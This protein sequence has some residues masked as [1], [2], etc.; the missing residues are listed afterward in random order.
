VRTIDVPANGLDRKREASEAERANV[1]K[2]LGLLA[3]RQLSATFYVVA[4]K[5]GG[6]RLSGAVDSD[7]DQACVVSLEP[8]RA[9]NASRF[10]VEFQADI[11]T[12]DNDEDVSIL[13]GPD[14]EL[15]EHGTIPVG[16]IVFET[17]SASL[18]PYPRAEGAEFS[19]A[20]PLQSKG[21]GDSPFAALSRLK[22]KD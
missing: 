4:I 2:A 6:Y 12:P 15:L 3:L 8:V 7:L 13:G 10:D 17:L 18:D 22:N 14:V 21:E 20:D 16:R 11:R 19:W 1:A 9:K 5:G